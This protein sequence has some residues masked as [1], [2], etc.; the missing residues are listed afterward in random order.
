M[1]RRGH[2]LVELL[3]V[4]T[5]LT[6]I[7]GGVTVLMTFMLHTR[8]DVRDRTYTVATVCRLSE[9]FRSD[10]HQSRSEPVVAADH[11]GV[12]LRL[13]NERTVRWQADDRDG[14]LRVEH[15]EG[16]SDR[17]NTY[18][19]PHGTITALET[20][21]GS[22]RMIVLRI[23]SPDAGGPAL[24]IEA[25]AGRDERLGVEEKL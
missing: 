6:A 2:T 17:Q 3:A 10:V 4:I 7:V 5:S 19:L 11:R 20:Q 22:N 24:A 15:A 25:L 14:M 21:P 13:S 23:E 12:E 16:S 1:K 8:D 18:F 9:Q